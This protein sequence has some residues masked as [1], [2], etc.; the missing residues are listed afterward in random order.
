MD[1]AKLMSCPLHNINET[2][3]EISKDNFPRWAKTTWHYD[4]GSIRIQNTA[5]NWLTLGSGSAINGSGQVWFPIIGI[6]VLENHQIESII[7]PTVPIYSNNNFWSIF[8]FFKMDDWRPTTDGDRRSWSPDLTVG[9][10]KSNSL[11]SKLI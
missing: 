10:D 5:R 8:Y 4:H 1:E 2:Y 3:N 11:I 6:R 9:P 7:Y